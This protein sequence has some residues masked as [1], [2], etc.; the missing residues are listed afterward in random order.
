MTRLEHWDVHGD[1]YER[2]TGDPD[3]TEKDELTDASTI[4][5]HPFTRALSIFHYLSFTLNQ[6]KINVL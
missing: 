3:I 5:L 2:H 1:W 6:I 4:I